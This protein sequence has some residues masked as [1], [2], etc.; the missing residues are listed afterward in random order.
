MTGAPIP[1]GDGPAPAPAAGPGAPANRPEAPPF[2]ADGLCPACGT[3]V[4]WGEAR[5]AFCRRQGVSPSGRRRMALHW[6]LV[7]AAMVALFGGSALFL[8]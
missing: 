8:P 7:L 2:R 5:C 3:S 4:P 6:V 1:R